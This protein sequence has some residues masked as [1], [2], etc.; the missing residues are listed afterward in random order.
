THPYCGYSD[1]GGEPLC[2]I[3]PVAIPSCPQLLGLARRAREEHAD[4]VAYQRAPATFAR[5]NEVLAPRTWINESLSHSLGPTTPATA[6]GQVAI[7]SSQSYELYL[8]GSFGRGLEV[9]V[10]GRKVGTVKDQLTTCTFQ[11]AC[12]SSN[13]PIPTRTSRPA[14]AK[15]WAPANSPKKPA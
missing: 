7:P 4:L 13:T 5:G 2:S 15:R 12:T 11:R 3:N 6:T 9:R 14:A 1:T 10:D 8:G